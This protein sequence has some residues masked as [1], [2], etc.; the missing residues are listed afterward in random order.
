MANIAAGPGMPV[1]CLVI[2]SLMELS[3]GQF[4]LEQRFQEVKGAQYAAMLNSLIAE[5]KKGTLKN[6][7]SP[8]TLASYRSDETMSCLATSR[9]SRDLASR[10]FV[11]QLEIID[12]W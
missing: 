8:E 5:K 11:Y 12:N 4:E 3:Q 10:L 1:G 7:K 6:S 9:I 2:N